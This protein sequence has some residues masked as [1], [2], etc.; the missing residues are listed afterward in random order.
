MKSRAPFGLDLPRASSSGQL[1]GGTE[2]QEY[3]LLRLILAPG[4]LRLVSGSVLQP[5][6]LSSAYHLQHNTRSMSSWSSC[7][8]SSQMLSH[9]AP[10]VLVPKFA[11][12]IIYASAKEKS[13]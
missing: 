12:V 2:R 8:L 10:L 7:R 9:I 6:T 11:C 4:S 5:G 1:R 13:I 3:H